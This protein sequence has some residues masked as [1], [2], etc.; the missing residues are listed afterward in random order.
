MLEM[1]HTHSR[2]RG[3][4][5]APVLLLGCLLPAAVA[6]AGSRPG[7]PA[8]SPRGTEPP[9]YERAIQPLLKARCYP[10]HGNG[11]KLGGFQVDTR[12]GILAGSLNTHPVVSPGRGNRSYLIRLVAGQVPGKVMPPR[13]AR[14]TRAE[15]AL[16]TRWVDAG[17]PFG[18]SGEGATWRAPLE[19]RRPSL[20]P[21]APGG[22]AHPLDR[23]LSRY[24]KATRFQTPAVAEDRV[25]ARRLYLDLIG[26]LPPPAELEAFLQDHNPD[27]RAR[28][29]DRLLARNR[30]YTEH[31]L[32]FWNDLLRNDYVGTGY[33]DGG[34]AS[35]TQWLY[36]ALW[37]NKP[38]DRF[39]SELVNPGPESA[40][41]VKGI[42][43]RG[44]VNAS[45]TP[46][47]Q[48]AQSISQVFLG[49]NLKCAS[50]HDSF[51]NTW[52]LAD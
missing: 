24:F 8:A 40:G 45:Q 28:L 52:K 31:W 30:E 10:C 42:V 26:L 34:R 11:S 48:A 49:V 37:E 20:P 41:F 9:S 18:R 47:M 13:G 33:I 50:C 46:P 27:R 21:A 39:V 36:R 6:G 12:A 15:V 35:I 44:V 7:R 4:R 1:P 43:W 16:L 51:I 3:Y 38:Y 22:S 25:F 32:S 19:P 14:L 5:V 29:A 23:L 2:T 17:L